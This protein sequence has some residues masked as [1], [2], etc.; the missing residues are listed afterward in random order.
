MKW[1]L[2]SLTDENKYHPIKLIGQSLSLDAG[3]S[4]LNMWL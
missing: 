3:L 2:D 1:V 4:D